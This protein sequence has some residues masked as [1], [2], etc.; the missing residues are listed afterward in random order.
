MGCSADRLSDAIRSICREI[1]EEA[2][3]RAGV[4]ASP[5]CMD[6]AQVPITDEVARWRTYRVNV[7]NLSADEAAKAARDV[8]RVS[9]ECGWSSVDDWGR[10]ALTRSALMDWLAAKR[11]GG[12]RSQ[13][14]K[15]TISR[16]RA[17]CNWIQA[18]SPSMVNPCDGLKMPRV[19]ACDRGPGMRAF[20]LAEV[21][22][23][24]LQAETLEREQWQTR[25]HAPN[26]SVLYCFLAHTG[27][28]Y[29]EAMRLQV[30]DVD[31]PGAML[32]VRA[33]KAGR[34]DWVPLHPEAVEAVRTLILARAKK[35][36]D[37]LFSKVWSE[38]LMADMQ[39]AGVPRRTGEGAGLWHS[40]R[41]MNVTER[42][43]AGAGL[44][45]VRRLARH[46]D[47]RTTMD[48]YARKAA[49]E[50]KKS[51]EI[52]PRLNGFLERDL[53]QFGGGPR[54][55]RVDS[56]GEDSDDDGAESDRSGCCHEEHQ[57]QRQ[58]P[59]PPRREA[60]DSATRAPAGRGSRGCGVD[61]ATHDVASRYPRGSNPLGVIRVAGAAIAA[62]A[63]LI[64]MLGRECS[65]EHHDERASDRKSE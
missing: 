21:R 51:A 42:L 41:K 14:V 63:D 27:L 3:H 38:T 9:R 15:N 39:A 19:R 32:R 1:I 6:G 24:I 31:L 44:E 37:P 60:A 34:G 58:D 54:E 49:T 57:P 2:L 16:L 65:A 59:C 28:R 56:G 61:G 50:L 64:E 33:D 12:A 23:L 62:L 52:L 29:G 5:D 45:D 53:R 26:R 11:A 25:R 47:S 18:R 4:C 10:G 17:W 40:F 8:V 48:H 36:D 30:S 43:I 20:S 7:D 22:A 46:V 55:K 13:T 35:P